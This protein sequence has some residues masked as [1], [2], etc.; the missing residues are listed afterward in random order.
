VRFATV[1]LTAAATNIRLRLLQ[2]CKPTLF[3]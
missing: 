3:E 2:L 1:D